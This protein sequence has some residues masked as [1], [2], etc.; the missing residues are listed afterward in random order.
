MAE[1]FGTYVIRNWVDNKREW[2]GMENPGRIRTFQNVPSSEEVWCADQENCSSPQTEK[3][4]HF[5]SFGPMQY[6][7]NILKFKE[8]FGAN[9]FS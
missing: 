3:H 7:F 5:A 6:E 8:E 1:E 4:I 2:G 9:G